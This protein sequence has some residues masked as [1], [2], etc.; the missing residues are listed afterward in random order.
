MN[1]ESYGAKKEQGAKLALVEKHKNKEA[2]NPQVWRSKFSPSL[3]IHRILLLLFLF[4][5]YNDWSNNPE[6]IF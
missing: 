5:P 3:H 6:W 2:D 4:L 1:P